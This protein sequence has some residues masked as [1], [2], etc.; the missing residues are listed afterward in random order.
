M[1]EFVSYPAAEIAV[2]TLATFLFGEDAILTSEKMPDELLSLV[3]E[4]HL[5]ALN[6]EAAVNCPVAGEIYYKLDVDES[7]SERAIISTVE[8]RCAFPVFRFHRLVEVAF[9][10]DLGKGDKGKLL[11][12]VELRR[13]GLIEH[14][15]YAGTQTKLGD[16]INL[17]DYPETLGLPVQVQTN[18]EDL[19][20]RHVPFWRAGGDH[21]ISIF[22]GKEGLIDA[23]YG[24]YS[25]DQHDA[26][27]SKKRVAMPEQYIKRDANNNIIFDKNTDVMAL[28]DDAMPALGADSKP[29]IPIDFTDSTIMGQRIAQRIDEFLLACG[30]APQSAGRDVTGGA[31]S[32]TARRLAQALTLMTVAT[33]GRYFKA[34]LK[35]ILD[36]AL[37]E[38]EPKMLQ[39]K[40][41]GKAALDV[42]V[43]MR[44][45]FVDDLV[46]QTTRV[47]AAKG[48]GVMSTETAVRELHSDWTDE[49]IAEEVK[50]IEDEEGA[51][52]PNFGD[53]PPDPNNPDVEP[54]A[55]GDSGD[56][57]TQIEGATP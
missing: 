55:T 15:L 19:L 14:R 43:A 17:N 48:G 57:V 28:S 23:L 50:R 9:V 6:L 32:G 27:M 51:K 47:V 34:A 35:D 8:A 40:T 25:Q 20:V 12:H 44:D 5:H 16:Q 13:K 37:W 18:I 41:K 54:T 7:V 52:L 49:Q 30:I 36:L 42:K 11:R 10:R 56:P 33:T 4:N 2:R 46:E 29:I 24:L 31:E 3:E 53:L 21:G 22:R 38:V 26:E 1:D 39:R 45:G